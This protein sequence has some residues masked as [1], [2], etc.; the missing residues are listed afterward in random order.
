MATDSGAHWK[1]GLVFCAC[2]VAVGTGLAF[3]GSTDESPPTTVAT[4]TTATLNENEG[5]VETANQSVESITLDDSTAELETEALEHSAYLEAHAN[6]AAAAESAS[7]ELSAS[8]VEVGMTYGE[9]YR[10]L[11]AAGISA[12]SR[13]DMIATGYQCSSEDLENGCVDHANL[14]NCSLVPHPEVESSSTHLCRFVFDGKYGGSI[15][16][17]TN[18]VDQSS[19]VTEIWSHAAY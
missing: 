19:L 10:K 17:D 4:S 15:T 8:G 3:V 7:N 11:N 1:I 6:M 2:C 12:R 16:V 18:G 5:L 13:S 14:E 9:A